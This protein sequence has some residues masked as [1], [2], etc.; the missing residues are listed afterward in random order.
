M[1][2]T[3]W[4]VFVLWGCASEGSPPTLANVTLSPDRVWAG[5]LTE[6]RADIDFTDPDG[7]LLELRVDVDGTP[8][9]TVAVSGAAGLTQGRVNVILQ[10]QPPSEGTLALR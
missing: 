2:H 7:D 3:L 8:P 4:L 1:K 6:V 5:E 9:Q 10:L